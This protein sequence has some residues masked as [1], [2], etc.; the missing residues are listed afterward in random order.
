MHPPHDSSAR[1]VST[2]S[3]VR[4][5]R[6]P[7]YAPQTV[8]CRP[9]CAE[10]CGLRCAEPEAEAEGPP[11]TGEGE[12]RV[13][14]VW[15]RVPAFVLRLP[16]AG[17]AFLGLSACVCEQP[18]GKWPHCPLQMVFGAGQAQVC[19]SGPAIPLFWDGVETSWKPFV[20]L[21]AQ[22]LELLQVDWLFGG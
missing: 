11:T 3:V 19:L 16:R 22:T 9:Q 12:V 7:V 10:S 21:K 6:G 13:W 15:V 8:S 17:F 20:Q 1:R 5:P 2:H 14:C 4:C 18:S